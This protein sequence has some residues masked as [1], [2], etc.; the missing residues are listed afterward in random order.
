MSATQ[1]VDLPKRIRAPKVSRMNVAR[2]IAVAEEI[3]T[4]K[5]ALK[6][7]EDRMDRNDHTTQ[8]RFTSL[9]NEVRTHAANSAR[10]FKDQNAKLDILILRSAKEDGAQEREKQAEESQISFWAK[11][12][13][14]A[15][16]V[17][18]VAAVLQPA[19]GWLRHIVTGH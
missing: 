18:T 15:I 17:G 6:H 12:S 8:E 9:E 1:G 3:G 11:W 13:G 7:H 19:V 5:G 2:D 10:E 16:V 4:I 14:F